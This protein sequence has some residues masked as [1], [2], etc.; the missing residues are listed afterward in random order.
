MH[1]TT[2]HTQMVVH[3]VRDVAPKKEMLCLSFP[4]PIGPAGSALQQQPQKRPLEEE[5]V[6]EGEGAKKGRAEA[7]EE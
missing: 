5:P 1:H 7:E 4:L 6:A 3:R 2:Q